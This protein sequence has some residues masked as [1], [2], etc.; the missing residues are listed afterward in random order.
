LR[1]DPEVFPRRTSVNRR[2]LLT[3]RQHLHHS[4]NTSRTMDTA[5]GP[6]DRW[7]D[8]ARY[9]AGGKSGHRSRGPQGL[10]T[11]SSAPG[12]ARGQRPRGRGYGKCHR[13]QTAGA[14][15]KCC[16]LSGRLEGKPFARSEWQA[17]FRAA[18]VRVKRW[19]K[20]PPREQQC[21]RHGKPRA[22]QDQIGGE[23][24][25]GPLPALRFLRSVGSLIRKDR[26]STLG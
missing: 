1:D 21:S 5:G 15:D 9:G 6:G 16:R 8:A 25:L 19:G 10:A 17:R 7:R 22:V 3:S 26:A 4:L 2:T 13:N 23:G 18:Q 12:N 24:W 20:S 11:Q 14:L